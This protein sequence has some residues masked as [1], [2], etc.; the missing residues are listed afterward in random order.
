MVSGT[1]IIKS[2][3]SDMS[4]SLSLKFYFCVKSEEEKLKLLGRDLS[5]S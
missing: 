4:I 5:T 3:D 1:I 2:L